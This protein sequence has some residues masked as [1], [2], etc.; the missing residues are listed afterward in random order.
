MRELKE[1]IRKYF[2]FYN[3]KRFHQSLDYMTP[4]IMYKLFFKEVV[5][6]KVAS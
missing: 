3:G 6:K 2:K 4:E 5:F 1:G